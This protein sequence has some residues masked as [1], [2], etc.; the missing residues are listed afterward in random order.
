MLTASSKTS[1]V[2]CYICKSAIALLVA[3]H[4][5]WTLNAIAGLRSPRKTSLK[6]AFTCVKFASISRTWTDLLVAD[7]KVINNIWGLDKALV[8]KVSIII[9]R[10]K[11]DNLDASYLLKIFFVKNAILHASYKISKNSTLLT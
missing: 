5:F 8:S 2:T 10:L 3:L 11:S 9:F 1:L 7:V 4:I 6:R